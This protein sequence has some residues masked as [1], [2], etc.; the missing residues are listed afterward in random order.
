MYRWKTLKFDKDT[1]FFFKVFRPM[2][3]YII[4]ISDFFGNMLVIN[5]VL[6]KIHLSQPTKV[7]MQAIQKSRSLEVDRNL[8]SYCLFFLTAVNIVTNFNAYI[9]IYKLVFLV[10]RCWPMYNVWAVKKI[11]ELW[12]SVT[13]T[14]SYTCLLAF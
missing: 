7:N 9:W 14:V 4:I 1:Y 13:F 8:F 5:P 12:R 2:K 3:N 11:L 6:F 10:P